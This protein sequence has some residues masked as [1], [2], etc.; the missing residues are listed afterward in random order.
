[1]K[2][3]ILI[4]TTLDFLTLFIV[5]A[6]MVICFFGIIG[7][8]FT[9]YES[10]QLARQQKLP[11]MLKKALSVGLAVGLVFTGDIYTISLGLLI[12]SFMAT[13]AAEHVLFKA[14]RAGKWRGALTD[15]VLR[16][17]VHWPLRL[18]WLSVLAEIYIRLLMPSP[19]DPTVLASLVS[20]LA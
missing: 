19:K 17:L 4:L 13:N 1:M 5:P 11:G 2:L 20:A 3:L 14:K 7:L 9:A 6:L 10:A 16:L 12:S 8:L 15:S 18:A